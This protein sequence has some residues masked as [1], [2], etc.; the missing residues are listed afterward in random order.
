MCPWAQ[1]GDGEP[2]PLTVGSFQGLVVDAG[3]DTSGDLVDGTTRV[4]FVTDL[5]TE[6][7]ATVLGSLR[8]LDPD[9]EP[10]PIPGIPSE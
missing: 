1:L 4:S 10:A 9:T 7:A 5:T 6:D 2:Q 3:S 8:P